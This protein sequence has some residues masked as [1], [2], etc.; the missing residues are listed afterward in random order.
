MVREHRCDHLDAS[1]FAQL[2]GTGL[3]LRQA[4]GE[5]SQAITRRRLQ[6]TVAAGQ[7][8]ADHAAVGQAAADSAVAQQL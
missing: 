2:Q 5:G 8:A 3:D 1:R 4:A 7:V 6:P